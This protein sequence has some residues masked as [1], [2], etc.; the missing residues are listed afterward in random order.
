MNKKMYVLICII[1]VVFVVGCGLPTITISNGSQAT[2]VPVEPTI[3]VV[4]PR[5]GSSRIDC[6]HYC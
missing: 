6:N 4:E 3:A 5:S 1:L 2:A